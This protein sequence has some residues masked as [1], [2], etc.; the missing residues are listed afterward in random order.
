VS[1]SWQRL[2]IA[3][4]Q[5]A[6]G[7][8]SALAAIDRLVTAMVDMGDRVLFL[9]AATDGD[10]ADH[11]ASAASSVDRAVIREI[12]R[13]QRIGELDPTVEPQWLERIIWS[14][15]YT[16]LHATH[17]GLVPRH[18]ASDLIRWTLRG[19]IATRSTTGTRPG[20]GTG[21]TST[22]RS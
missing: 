22:G 18:G 11:D 19:A 4:R 2:H 20:M 10:V 12:R 15:V 7:E 17:D 3:I 16:G 1:D 5:A 13:G 9:F 8:G 14:T 6:L 21:P